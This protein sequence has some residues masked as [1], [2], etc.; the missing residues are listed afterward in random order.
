MSKDW[1]SRIIQD[2]RINVLAIPG[3]HDAAS[4][5]GA[6][7][8]PYTI[9]QQLDITKQLDAGVRVLDMRVS[10]KII[11]KDPGGWN[12]FRKME[13][14]G[15]EIHM[16]HASRMFD[17]KLSEALTSI[18][19]WL[20]D[21]PSEFVAMI[22]QQQGTIPKDVTEKQRVIGLIT[23]AIWNAFPGNW[24]Y[25]PGKGQNDWP[26]VG[27]LKKKVMVFSR[28]QE[29]VPGAFDLRAWGD[30]MYSACYPVP[31]TKLKVAVQDRYKEVTN[32]DLTRHLK[33]YGYSSFDQIQQGKILLFENLHS[34]YNDDPTLKIN[35]LSHSLLSHIS[36]PQPYKIGTD[37]N[38]RLKASIENKFRRYRG[39]VM[40]D[41]ANATVCKSIIDSN[42]IFRTC[43]R[44]TKSGAKTTDSLGGPPV[45]PGR[46]RSKSF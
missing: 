11:T 20:G 21:N 40:I 44:R 6:D 16:C 22:F 2:T 38:T 32:T 13:V 17:T 9:T 12:P 42:L 24:V 34:Q 23:T 39:F 30:N 5:V 29:S 25:R 35:H 28:L 26:M 27:T 15:D 4:I 10:H 1:L 14:V 33:S 31:E 7:W 41:D 43:S 45:G 8:T 19:N 37:L 3:T 46:A 36:Y 18:K